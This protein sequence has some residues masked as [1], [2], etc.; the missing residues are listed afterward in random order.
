MRPERFTPAHEAHN[1]LCCLDGNSRIHLR[2]RRNC[3]GAGRPIHDVW[4]WS[5]LL[6]NLDQDKQEDAARQLSIYDLDESWVAGF[7]SGVG[8]AGFGPLRK[9]DAAA[10]TTFMDQYCQAHPLESISSA[11]RRLVAELAGQ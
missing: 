6:R 2:C 11:A 7:V 3:T 1:T 4:D 9:T 5:L 10:L 8:A